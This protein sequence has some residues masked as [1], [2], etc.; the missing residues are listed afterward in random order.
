[1]LEV[2]RPSYKHGHTIL[3]PPSPCPSLFSSRQAPT[4]L[5]TINRHPE[6]RRT[7]RRAFT[8]FAATGLAEQT[9]G[10]GPAKGRPIQIDLGRDERRLAAGTYESWIHSVLPDLLKPGMSMWDLGAHI[11]YYVITAA[12]LS[13]TGAHLAVEADPANTARLRHN[14]ALNDI[15]A[16]ILEV[17]V[18]DRDREIRFET[19]SELGHKRFGAGPRPSSQAMAPRSNG[20]SATTAAAKEP[21]GSRLSSPS[22]PSPTPSPV[23]IDPRPTEWRSATTGP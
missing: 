18:S 17:A 8:P 14:L 15:D 10:R 5:L 19:A 7:L 2:P 16:E 6:L 20:S 9:I 22:P 4:S 12:T 3:T 1:V 23:P 11:G 21:K 13:P